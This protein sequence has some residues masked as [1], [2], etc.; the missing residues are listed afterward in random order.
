MWLSA[1]RIGQRHQSQKPPQCRP[2]GRQDAVCLC[3]SLREMEGDVIVYAFSFTHTGVGSLYM[4]TETCVCPLWRCIRNKQ[5]A[6][7]HIATCLLLLLSLH[8][9][10]LSVNVNTEGQTKTLRHI[11]LFYNLNLNIRHIFLIYNLTQAAVA[12]KYFVLK[13]NFASSSLKFCWKEERNIWAS[14]PNHQNKCTLLVSNQSPWHLLFKSFF[15]PFSYAHWRTHMLTWHSVVSHW[16][17][18]RC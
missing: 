9:P 17:D 14:Y 15:F 8:Y 2:A 12:P 16:H 7:S 11:F 13:H 10:D 3:A 5:R 6:T 4:I 1:C 18:S